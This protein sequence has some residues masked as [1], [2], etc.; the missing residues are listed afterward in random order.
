MSF[1]FRSTSRFL[2]L[3]MLCLTRFICVKF[4]GLQKKLLENLKGIMCCLLRIGSLP[5]HFHSLGIISNIYYT[6]GDKYETWYIWFD[7]CVHFQL[8]N[9]WI[10]LMLFVIWNEA[11]T[12]SNE[13]PLDCVS[14]KITHPHLSSRCGKHERHTFIKYIKQF[15]WNPVSKIW[16]VQQTLV[17]VLVFCCCIA[18]NEGML[19]CSYQIASFFVEKISFHDWMTF[20]SKFSFYSIWKQSQQSIL[21]FTRVNGSEKKYAQ[22]VY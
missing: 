17:G 16:L 11:Q 10:I 8:L 1:L 21:E 13:H 18:W 9:L 12:K 15:Q 7:M 6:P 19:L 3:L 2:L 22:N 14:S 4:N 20:R 5:I